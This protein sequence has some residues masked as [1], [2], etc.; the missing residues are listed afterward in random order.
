MTTPENSG[1]ENVDSL[2][3]A[4]ET[5]GTTCAKACA[6]HKP[7][8]FASL[9]IIGTGLALHGALAYS[10]ELA[11]YVPESVVCSTQDGC[12]IAALLG[13]GCSSRSSCQ[14]GGGGCA[15]M[16]GCCSQR[17]INDFALELTTDSATV[18][19]AEL[20]ADALTPI[21]AEAN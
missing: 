6:W 8:W 15:L 7:F 14:S 9:A 12:P 4:A 3:S 13:G 2:S 17:G 21:S 1:A 16:S 19:I 11:N 18:D 5:T 20:P 10:P